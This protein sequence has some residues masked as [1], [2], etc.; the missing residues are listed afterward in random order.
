LGVAFSAVSKILP[1]HKVC[2]AA[3]CLQYG[4]TRPPHN[5]WAPHFRVVR[6]GPRTVLSGTAGAGPG[7]CRCLRSH[8]PER[9]PP[10]AAPSGAPV[11]LSR[12]GFTHPTLQHCRAR[13]GSKNHTMLHCTG[14]QHPRLLRATVA[15]VAAAA[16][17]TAL[18]CKCT[19]LLRT[20]AQG[21]HRSTYPT[22]NLYSPPTG[23]GIYIAPRKGLW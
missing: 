19:E 23:L 15:A 5:L 22:R 13:Q 4:P 21:R 16:H 7:V 14:L 9:L 8:I 10:N 3:D 18:H 17:S 20:W 6:P 1:V 12:R 11:L 2:N